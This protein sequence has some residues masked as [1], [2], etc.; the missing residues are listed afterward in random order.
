MALVVGKNSYV[1]VDQADA[2][3]SSHYMSSSADWKRWSSL[4]RT[5]KKV[6]LLSACQDIEQLPFPGRKAVRDQELCF[7][8]Y[9]WGQNPPGDVLAAQV[10]LALWL[11]DEDKQAQLSHRQELQAQ[12]V[13]SFRLGDLS[14]SYGEGTSGGQRS[15]LLCPKAMALLTPYMSGRFATC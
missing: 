13:T 4:D 15:A 6:L 5:D 2:Y 8:R 11:S 7:P 14:E 1:T 12:G 10:E 9:G 3:I